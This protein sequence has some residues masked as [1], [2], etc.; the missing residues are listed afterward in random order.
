MMF[1]EKKPKI[2]KKSPAFYTWYKYLAK[3]I[4]Q[5]S[6]ISCHILLIVNLVEELMEI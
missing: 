6:E 3:N 5:C 2:E 1:L 4:N